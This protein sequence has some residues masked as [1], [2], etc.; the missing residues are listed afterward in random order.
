MIIR[1]N[2]L[3]INSFIV[4]III[5][6]IHNLFRRIFAKYYIGMKFNNGSIVKLSNQW[7]IL[8]SYRLFLFSFH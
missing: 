5:E 2:T 4:E 1:T 3:Q 6:P 8:L 7:I